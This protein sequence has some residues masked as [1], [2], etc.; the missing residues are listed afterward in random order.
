[1]MSISG[2][3]KVKVIAGIFVLLLGASFCIVNK[4]DAFAVVGTTGTADAN[5]VSKD[6]HL[7]MFDRMMVEVYREADAFTIGNGS[8]SRG[9][10]PIKIR[11]SSD[12]YT[13]VEALS[14]PTA[15]ETLLVGKHF[16]LAKNSSDSADRNLYLVYSANDAAD[17]IG[18]CGLP[19]GSSGGVYFTELTYDAN[20]EL[21]TFQTPIIQ[22]NDPSKW[23]DTYDSW[24]SMTC[25]GVNYTFHSESEPKPQ[26]W[27]EG[28]NAWILYDLRVRDEGAVG[29]D[30]TYLRMK[31]YTRSVSGWNSTPDKIR[32]IAYFQNRASVSFD[33]RTPR[34]FVYSAIVQDPENANNF[35]VLVTVDLPNTNGG[36]EST[37]EPNVAGTGYLSTAYSACTVGGS[38]CYSGVTINRPLGRIVVEKN[39]NCGR[40]PAVGGAP[41]CSATAIADPSIPYPAANFSAIT[42]GT[43]LRVV[44]PFI[45]AG[46]PHIRQAAAV[47]GVWAYTDM[48]V[49]GNFTLTT[50]MFPVIGGE[51]TDYWIVGATKVGPNRF[52]E[53]RKFNSGN[54]PIYP[55]SGIGTV[56][57]G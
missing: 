42:Q 41:T 43:S 5:G 27:V 26:I 18:V 10:G 55:A 38:P 57:E 47:G 8:T 30:Y 35:S 25:P 56:N 28:T 37:Y 34:N 49:A 46:D 54:A 17:S 14:N 52:I 9:K 36:G 23:W 48:S 21:W 50:E 11:K 29:N 4:A 7:V 15:I 16:F 31:T 22:V 33:D 1:M 3:A 45:S 40:D 20:T 32:D 12:G 19:T 53:Y 51:G 2:S 44:Y 24:R 6:R 13:W 39:L